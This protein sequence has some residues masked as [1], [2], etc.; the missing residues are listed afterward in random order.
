MRAHGR[1]SLSTV[2]MPRTMNVCKLLSVITLHDFLVDAR[3]SDRYS[4]PGRLRWLGTVRCRRVVG[5]R[6]VQARELKLHCKHL[7]ISG[8]VTRPAPRSPSEFERPHLG[9]YP[10]SPKRP[11]KPIRWVDTSMDLGRPEAKPPLRPLHPQHKQ[12]GCHG[13]SLSIY[14][15]ATT[16]YR[17]P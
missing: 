1:R 14:R 5:L 13:S 4:C 12:E 7:F 2:S 17:F 3:A 10:L 16:R 11:P 8:I 15:C 6:P 9:T